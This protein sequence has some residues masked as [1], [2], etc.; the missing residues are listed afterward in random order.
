MQ[1]YENAKIKYEEDIETLTA[2]AK[3]LRHRIS[4]MTDFR[5]EKDA[6]RGEIILRLDEISKSLTELYIRISENQKDIDT[7]TML[8]TAS[9]E[10]IE[11]F[12]QEKMTLSGR[13][14]TQEEQIRQTTEAMEKNRADHEAANAELERLNEK[15]SVAEKDNFEFERK[16][17][18]LNAKLR[19]RMNHKEL[20]FREHTKCETK[21]MTLRENQAKLA[22]K[23]WDDYE[24]TRA[25]AVALG[26]PP[27]TKENRTEMI[28]LQTECKNKLRVMGNV[29]LDA[30]NKYAEV[31]ERYDF[32]SAQ[33]ADLT[34]SKENLLEII[35]KLEDEVVQKVYVIPGADI[36]RV[37]LVGNGTLVYDLY[38]DGVR[39]QRYDINGL[40]YRL[41]LMFRTTAGPRTGE[42]SKNVNDS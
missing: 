4:E 34:Q 15:R 24:L 39:E 14:N 11:T 3:T 23:L 30:V 37:D 16:L 25:D 27:V 26:Y 31:K 21:L 19:D 12:H 33:I 9:E 5:M 22:T 18:E 38:L 41:E 36:V 20:V 13:I 6:E 10:R 2:E 35:I 40:L 8:K 32:M 7:A 17:N 28:A 29:D 42:G 1:E